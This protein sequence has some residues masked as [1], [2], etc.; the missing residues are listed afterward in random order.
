[1]NWYTD[2]DLPADGKLIVENGRFNIGK[3]GL[4]AILTLKSGSSIA[5]S[6]AANINKDAILNIAG[7]DVSLNSNDNWAGKIT[8]TDGNLTLNGIN[9]N[10]IIDAQGGILNLNSGSLN[11]GNNSVIAGS[12]ANPAVTIADNANLNVTGG[13]VTLNSNDT[14]SGNVNLV[15][16]T[17][18]I[19]DVA[20]NG[21]IQAADG[22]LNVNSGN[23]TV[24]NGS[25]I[26][27]KVDTYI[28]INS[29]IDIKDKGTVTIN[30]SLIHI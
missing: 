28:D 18:N 29:T 6:A 21:K 9:S 22:N 13:D 15:S 26:N 5:E 4:N 1:M 27:S 30:L 24:E 17:L 14:W 12:G 7:A 19:E 25:F 16:G 3:D 2:K 10:G 23:L 11:V 8:L 20:S